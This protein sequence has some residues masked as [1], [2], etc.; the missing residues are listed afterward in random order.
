MTGH[1]GELDPATRARR[2]EERRVDRM[3]RGLHDH[4]APYRC[5][6]KGCV[7]CE[8]KPTYRDWWFEIDTRLAR[9]RGK[10]S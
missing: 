7:R 9:K 2:A 6:L 8:G 4:T 10:R 5:G 1:R 3:T